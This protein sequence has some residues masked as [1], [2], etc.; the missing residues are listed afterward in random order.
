[1][2]RSRR[3]A[4]ELERRRRERAQRRQTLIRRLGYGGAAA[5]GLALV[6]A[7]VWSL[8]GG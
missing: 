5:A 3:H 7:V 4:R 8:V 2:S 6:A 1:M